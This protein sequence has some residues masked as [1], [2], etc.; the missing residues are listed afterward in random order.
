MF[1]RTTYSRS[2]CTRTRSPR[3]RKRHAPKL[4]DKALWERATQKVEAARG[5]KE[6]KSL[7]V[8]LARFVGWD[9]TSSGVEQTFTKLEHIAPARRLK[10]DFNRMDDLV[11][12]AT[13]RDDDDA[14][15]LIC[16]A[17]RV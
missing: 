1:A 7:L 5:G 8:V 10:L 14:E 2:G 16:G 13:H 4:D 11:M 9:V 3:K 15:A 6:I 17:E 12:L